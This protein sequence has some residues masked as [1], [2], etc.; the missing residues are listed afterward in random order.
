MRYKPA[1]ATLTSQF[2]RDNDCKNCERFDMLLNIQIFW[3]VT[4]CLSVSTSQRFLG[5]EC[6]YFERPRIVNG[7]LR[8]EDEGI[9]SLR[10]T[11]NYSS[12]DT[13]SHSRRLYS[14]LKDKL[15]THHD[16][17]VRINFLTAKS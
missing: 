7:Q 16:Q 17:Y 12:E 1:I 9:P 11:R 10:N 13:A 15:F 6:P 3:V 8:P 14:A 4:L 2:N 5:S